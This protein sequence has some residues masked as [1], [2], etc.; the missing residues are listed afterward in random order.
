MIQDLQ[1]ELKLSP[2]RDE[3]AR[4]EFV[5]SLRGYILVDMASS[6]KDR[7]EKE[8]KPLYRREYGQDPVD[9]PA[10]HNAMK[11]DLYFRFYSSI[12]YNAQE[13]VWQSVV[14]VVER[15]LDDLIGQAR[16]LRDGQNKV[17]GSIHLNSKVEIPNNVSKIDVHLAPGSYHTEY[18]EDDV[19]TGTIYDNGLNIF[20]S[21]MMGR[22]LSDIGDSMSNYIRLKY[23]DFK[24]QKILDCGCTIGHNTAPWAKTFPDAEVHAIDVSA[25]L[26]RYANARAQAQK[27]PI[28]F[29]QMNATAL[30]FEDESFDIVFSSM[31]LHE[32]PL[33][34]IH[35]YMKEAYR[36][37]RPGGLMLNMEL[38]PNNEMQPYDSFYLD[39]DS[40]YNEEP[41]YKCFRD[42]SYAELCVKA[43][44]ETENFV[45]IVT[46]QYGY[47][48][49]TV[50]ERA[51]GSNGPIDDRVGRLTEGIQWFGFGAWK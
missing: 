30:D 44:F 5:S 10:V 27:T 49:E 25:P 20:A 33:K 39:W 15:D 43:G 28:H 13:M 9:G 36:V 45:Q 34:D 32:L 3:S 48:D 51:I 41:Y 50:F 38:P 19:A 46:P 23:P 40:Y 18:T 2:S 47:V 37:L 42:Q 7:Y 11:S 35:A 16:K 29:T 21:N 8:V 17:K 14:P 31:F 26:L 24:P 12:R 4:Q 6:M 22:N 1:H